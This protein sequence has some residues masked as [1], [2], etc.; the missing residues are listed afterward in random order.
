M[1]VAEGRFHPAHAAG[2]PPTLATYQML[3]SPLA[4]RPAPAVPWRCMQVAAADQALQFGQEAQDL[5]P[6]CFPWKNDISNS[7]DDRRI[8]S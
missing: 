3:L 8:Y 7:S 1:R 4:E 2:K 6:S 5:P